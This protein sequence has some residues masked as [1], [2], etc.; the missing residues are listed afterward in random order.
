MAAQ[1]K[2][3]E[4]NRE[5]AVR[6]SQ[7]LAETDQAQ[8]ISAASGP[9]TKAEQDANIATREQA[10]AVQKAKL[11]ENQ[12]EA[13][14]KKPADARLYEVRQQAEADKSRTIAEAEAEAKAVRLRGEADAEAIRLRGE[15]EAEALLKRAEALKQ[16]N[17]AAVL[18][19]VM[20]RLPEV[21]HELAAPMGNIGDLTVISTDGAGSLP[22]TVA[23][24]FG[25]LD[26]LIKSF[27]GSSVSEIA[28]GY[29]A[30]TTTESSNDEVAEGTVV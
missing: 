6:Q 21:A 4:K 19:L 15:A 5:L 10:V 20:N 25:Q 3:A 18:E 12:L 17:E 22:K 27:T 7:L 8:A 1:T 26:A 2:I 28:S 30:D 13:E 16:F 23:S 11:R 14:V 29:S 9:L 24:N